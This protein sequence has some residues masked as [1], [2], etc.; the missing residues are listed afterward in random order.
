MSGGRGARHEPKLSMLLLS[1]PKAA[2]GSRR[3]LH[4]DGWRRMFDGGSAPLGNAMHLAWTWSKFPRKRDREHRLAKHLAFIRKQGRR[5]R[6]GRECLSAF[7]NGLLVARCKSGRITRS[8]ARLY[9]RPGYFCFRVVG[10]RFRSN[11][12][13]AGECAL[14]SGCRGSWSFCGRHGICTRD[15]SASHGQQGLRVG[16]VSG[17][18]TWNIGPHHR[19]GNTCLG[20]M[21]LVVF[22]ECA[23]RPYCSVIYCRCTTRRSGCALSRSDRDRSECAGVRTFRRRCRHAGY[24]RWAHCDGRDRGRSLLSQS[25]RSTTAPAPYANVAIRSFPYTSVYP[26]DVDIRLLLCRTNSGLRLL[27]VSI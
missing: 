24:W 5:D 23:I 26:I 4:T 10:L 25:L 9:R 7:G 11:I 1:W 13:D 2:Q 6:L 14:N 21:A 20:K 19:G 17:G 16:R 18:D 8:E 22:G 12:T 15:L 27:A 3:K